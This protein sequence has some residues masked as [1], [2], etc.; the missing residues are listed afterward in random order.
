MN[1]SHLTLTL[2]NDAATARLGQ[3]IAAASRPGDVIVA[4][5]DLGAGKT[6]LFRA[7]IRALTSPAE[8]VPSPTYTLVQTYEGRTGRIWHFDFYRLA[9]PSE[10]REIGLD[11]GEQDIRLIEWPERIG[12]LVPARRLEVELRYDG[13]GRIARLTD[14]H[15]WSLRL[16]GEWS[17]S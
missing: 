15:D 13:D 10:A 8:E 2:G 9:H 5:G 7:A 17:R 6:A 12:L 16:H 11:E 14:H 4:R 1:P 3:R